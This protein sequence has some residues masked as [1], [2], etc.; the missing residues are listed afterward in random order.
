VAALFFGG[1]GTTA[2][3]QSAAQFGFLALR[4][5]GSQSYM[6]GVVNTMRQVNPSIKLAHYTNMIDAQLSNPDPVGGVIHNLMADQIN[7]ND[8]WKRNASG[9]LTQWTT[10]YATYI[11]NPTAWA[12]KDASGRRWPQVAAQLETDLTLSKVSGLDYIYV[13]N[14][15]WRPRTTGDWK[16]NGTNQLNTDPVIQ[17]AVRQ[18]IVDYFSALRTLNPGKKIIGNADNDLSTAE[19][20]GKLEGAYNECAMGKSWS[21][22]TWAGWNSMMSR[23]RLM[24][25]NTQGPKDVIFEAC[26]PNGPDLNM[27]RYG[28]ASALLEDG[29]YAYSAA[30]HKTFW[31]DEYSAPLGT[32]AEAPPTVATASGIWLRRYTG[33]MVLV[34]PGTTTASVNIGSGYKRLLGT[35]DP[36]TNNGQPLS[37]V[38]LLPRQGLILVKQ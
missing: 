28:M 29:W 4:M 25:A 9:Q 34:N 36:A 3:Q 33:G 7:A 27:L 11:V 30:G 14:V 31:A 6:Q 21:L 22:E 15:W 32:A 37:T 10:G 23:Y 18:G 13:D 5:F 17:A 2:Q 8:W 16:R 26:G 35:Q 19:Y 38:T 12:P 1:H 24:L 20:K